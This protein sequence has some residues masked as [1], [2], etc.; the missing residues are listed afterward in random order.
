MIATLSI[1]MRATLPL[2]WFVALLC[3]CEIAKA[4]GKWPSVHPNTVIEKY[5]KPDLVDSTEY[6]N[7]RPPFVTRYLIYRKERVRFVFLA[8]APVGSPPPYSKWRLM[9]AQDTRDNSVLKAEEI[10]RR[11]QGR[12]K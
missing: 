11:M 7:P 8:D 9:G 10:T 1:A 5:S 2:V 6:A 4:Q 12:T 3:G